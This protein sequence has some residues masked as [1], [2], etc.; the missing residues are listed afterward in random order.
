MTTWETVE[1]RIEDSFIAVY[2]R[3]WG[4]GPKQFWK[5]MAWCLQP[6]GTTW[7]IGFNVAFQL[8]LSE[9]W[10]LLEEEKWILT[11]ADPMN[12]NGELRDLSTISETSSST[13]LDVVQCSEKKLPR[14]WSGYCVLQDPPTIVVTRPAKKPGILKIVDAKNYGMQNPPRDVDGI[15]DSVGL[16]AWVV[17]W[18]RTI[19]DN[20]LGGL[21]ATA[22]SQSMHAFKH[23]YMKSPLEIH[24]DAAAITLERDSLYC[25]RNECF[26]I[27]KVSGPVYHLDFNSFYLSVAENA[28]VP[29]RL[30]GC[31]IGTLDKINELRAM[32]YAVIADV[33]MEVNSPWFPK[34]QG[35][36]LMFPIGFFQTT[37]AGPELFE[38]IDCDCV[39][40]VGRIAWYETDQIF[41]QWVQ[42][43]FALRMKAREQGDSAGEEVFKRVGVSVFGKFA[44]WDWSWQTIYDVEPIT[45]F[46]Q[47]WD[48]RP[49]QYKKGKVLGDKS[50]EVEPWDNAETKEYCR[51]RSIGWQVQCEST[52]SEHRESCPAITSWI[53]SLA[54]VRLLEAIKICGW[55]NVYYC[56]ADSLWTN[57]S[58]YGLLKQH[59]YLHDTALGKLKEKACFA[60]VKFLGLKHYE[61]PDQII[62]AG[63]PY[64]ARQINDREWEFE[65]PERLH[66][67]LLDGRSPLPHLC[68]KSAA[69]RQPYRH[70]IVDMQGKVRPITLMENW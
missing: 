55:P 24:D 47:W 56:D 10:D 54:R 1:I 63:V 44:Q 2:E 38:A 31:E 66:A 49:E 45:P 8:G 53:Y 5:H 33:S 57:H 40:K 30:K 16:A 36:G 39:L 34:R 52:R 35:E 50:G 68:I 65:S 43:L 23:K 20:K 12:C 61:L 70:G 64:H 25:G 14:K 22:A 58:G 46:G 62:H 32:G 21:Q 15:V 18:V 29:T 41:R 26:R 19:R 59:G 11:D 27:G 6:G 7:A 9:F 60:S 4:E 13:T 37:L 69:Y 17:G 42:E 48:V 67:A 28:C 51:W 3:V